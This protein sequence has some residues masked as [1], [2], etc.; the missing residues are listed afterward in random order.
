MTNWLTLDEA[1]A[2]VSASKRT[3]ERWIK[4]RTLVAHKP[5]RRILIDER[6]LEKFVRRFRAS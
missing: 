3:V 5:G 2:R 4:D 6:E 1:A